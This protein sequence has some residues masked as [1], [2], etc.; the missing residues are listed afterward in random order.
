[1]NDFNS[2]GYRTL[3]RIRELEAENAKLR[4]LTQVFDDMLIVSH[5]GTLESFKSIHHAL[6]ALVEFDSSVDQYFHKQLQAVVDAINLKFK[7]GNSVPV[8]R[9]TITAAEWFKETEL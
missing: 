8:D 2:T 5:L 9:V 3:Q 7:S 1:M 6:R 4:E